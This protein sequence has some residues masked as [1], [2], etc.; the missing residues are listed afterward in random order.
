MLLPLRGRCT[1]RMP[2]LTQP[3]HFVRVWHWRLGIGQ[4]SNPSLPHRQG[5]A[6]NLT[7]SLIPIGTVLHNILKIL[8]VIFFLNQTVSSHFYLYFLNGT[9]QRVGSWSGQQRCVYTYVCVG[10]SVTLVSAE[11]VSITSAASLPSVN[12]I[13]HAH[14]ATELAVKPH[15]IYHFF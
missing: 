2:F 10:W 11:Q 13:A 1:P 5:K 3:S 15:N 14:I 7:Q 4:E 9:R 6:E 12:R 8:N